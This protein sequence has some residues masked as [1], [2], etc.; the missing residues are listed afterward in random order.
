MWSRCQETVVAQVVC[1]EAGGGQ[2][3]DGETVSVVIG[4]RVFIVL[5][6]LMMSKEVWE[7]GFES[8]FEYLG[9]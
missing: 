5:R 1:S 2:V 8:G 4:S 7:L 6:C 3:V 9:F